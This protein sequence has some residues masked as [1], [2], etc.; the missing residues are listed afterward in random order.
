MTT[1]L[2][3]NERN[4]DYEPV[5]DTISLGRRIESTEWFPITGTVNAQTL[6]IKLDLT[7]PEITFWY[8]R[9]ER[10]C[11]FVFNQSFRLT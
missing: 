8:R 10:C 1:D 2:V 7:H 9:L 4:K 6:D 5:H 11:Y 3:F